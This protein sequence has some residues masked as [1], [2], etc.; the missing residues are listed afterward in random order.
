VSGLGPEKMEIFKNISVSG[1]SVQKG[2]A[3]ISESE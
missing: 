3:D 1:M 2:I